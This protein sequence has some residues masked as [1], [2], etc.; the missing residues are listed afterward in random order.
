MVHLFVVYGYQRAEEDAD[1]LLLTD[2]LLQAVPA[3]VRA[4]CI[5][6]PMIIAGDLNADPAVI[7]YLAKGSLLV[8]LSIWLWHILVGLVL[9]LTSPVG[10]VVSMAL[11]RV[12]ISLS[13]VRKHWL[14]LMHALLQ[15]GGSLII[16]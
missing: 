12:G 8:G 1:Q 10:S 9:H 13:D 6:Q 14:L 4:V 7:P 5:G 15:I 2:E 3:E 16:L 11:V